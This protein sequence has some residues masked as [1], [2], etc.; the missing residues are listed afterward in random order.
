MPIVKCFL[1]GELGVKPIALLIKSRMLCYW[2][3][4]INAKNDK[5]CKILYKTTLAV[6]DANVIH[7]R[8]ISHVKVCL[9]SLGMSEYFIDQK[10]DNLDHFKATVNMRLFDQFLQS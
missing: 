8:W 7:S 2:C 9:D 1:F 6:H 5:I 3:K 4:L 10:V